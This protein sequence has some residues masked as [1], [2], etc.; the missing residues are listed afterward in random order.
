MI[1]PSQKVKSSI[2]MPGEQ[3]L[4]VLTAWNKGLL[5][6]K[7]KHT[8][9]ERDASIFNIIK[10]KLDDIP[11]D[12]NY[13]HGLL[14]N[15]IVDQPVDYIHVDYCGG[16]EQQTSQ[17]IE[18]L[19]IQKN[20]EINFT[21]AYAPR[22]NEFIKK[23]HIIFQQETWRHILFREYAELVRTDMN[24]AIYCC[25]IR[26]LLR[27]YHCVLDQPVYYK[28]AIQSMTTYRFRGFNKQPEINY[29]NLLAEFPKSRFQ[30][31]F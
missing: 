4:D 19:P 31:D 26:C 21:F 27:Q 13:H 17:W 24:I 20:A 1:R 8:I 18:T 12:F 22:N 28:D 11:I 3:C 23:C 10:E 7:G 25:I 14:A 15:Y 6:T 30:F 16:L 9:V 29:P 2:W 5:H